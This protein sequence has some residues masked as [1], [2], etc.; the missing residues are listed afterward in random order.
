MNFKGRLWSGAALGALAMLAAA[1]A[2]N[3]ADAKHHAKKAPAAAA[4]PAA[5]AAEV[6]A[7]K[8]QVAAL[9]A[10]VQ[11]LVQAQTKTEEVATQTEAVQTSL[12]N[13]LIAQSQAIN[14]MPAEIVKTAVAAATP[15][16]DKVYYKGV[17]VT[18]GGFLAAE[19]VYRQ[20]SEIA[21]IASSYS[22]L[23]LGNSNLHNVAEFRETARQSRIAALVEGNVNATTHAAF[24]GELDFL[25]AAQT[26]NSNESN[27]YNPRIRN[28]YGTVDWDASG[29]H[30]LAGQN[31]SLVTLNSKGISPRNEVT[32]PQIDAQYVPG[33]TWA[34][35]PQIRLTKDLMDKTL[36][37][38]VSAENPQTTASGTAANGV[39]YNNAAGSGFNSANSLS[40]NH[41]P[42][43]VAKV[44]YEPTIADRRVHLEAYGLFRDFYSRVTGGNSDIF[45][46]AFGFGATVPAIPKVLDVQ[47]SGLVGRGVG[48]YGSVGLADVTFDSQGNVK[49]LEE[50]AVLAGGTFHASPVLD[51]YLFGGEEHTGRQPYNI[52][53]TQ[54]GYGSA[55]LSNAGCSVVGGTCAG[56]TKLVDQLTVGFWHKVYQGSFGRVQWG[57][58]YSST[59]RS[60]YSGVGGAYNTTDSML[61]SSFRYYPF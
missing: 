42:D 55:L 54:Y 7:L 38:A 33:F 46:G 44:A 31:W 34:R 10:Q 11:Q 43:V 56:N 50:L 28:V 12:A 16:T 37:L 53:S 36:W 30:L 24:Y 40:I 20:R 61:F 32:P 35:Q 49:P 1:P 17:T 9:Q 58:Q 25:G 18:L 47:V 14:T 26:A 3:A 59:E 48:R 22:A 5:S 29:W 45:S 60:L 23:P 51:I 4:A 41:M 19:S 6:D 27:S 13:S 2:A 15:K 39:Y 8:A 57:L 52:G 21:D